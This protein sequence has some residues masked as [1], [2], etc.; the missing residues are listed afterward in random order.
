MFD[1]EKSIVNWRKQMLAAGIKTPVPLEELESHL[2]E[3]IGQQLK[4]GLNEQK[5]FEISTQRIGQPKM[6]KREFKKSERRF[7]KQIVKI[8]A[9]IV[10]VLVGMAFIIPAAAQ[11][12]HEGVMTKNDVVLYTFGMAICFAS[13]MLALLSLK[14]RKA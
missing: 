8:G 9:G 6:L 13:V 7:M 1:L 10:G 3:E 5:A 4:S 11:C 12:R 14:K 2:R